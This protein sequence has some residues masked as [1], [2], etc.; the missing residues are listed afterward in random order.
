MIPDIIFRNGTVCDGTG[1]PIREC[2]IA[3][4]NG[5]IFDMGEI[6]TEGKKE[7]DCSGLVVSPG[8]I[9]IHSHSDYTLVADP[10]ALSAIYQGVTLEVIGNCG[11]GCF[12]IRDPN[13]SKRIV[14]GYDGKI[15]LTW[16]GPAAYLHDL[17]AGR[18]AVNVI[19]LVPNGQL[20]LATV[21]FTEAPA[22]TS[23]IKDMKKLLEEGLE[24]GCWGYSTGL[25]YASEAGA[26]EK[27]ITELCK[28][29]AKHDVIYTTHTRN[30]DAGAVKSVVEAIRTARNAE[31]Q[32]Q[33]SHLMLRG[34]REPTLQ[35]IDLVEE[36]RA[37]GDPIWFDMHTRLYG[38]T[39][40]SAM[41]P[42]WVME[43]TPKEQKV[44]LKDQ[45]V[46][47]KIRAF[48]SIVTG[49]GDWSKVILTDNTVA[50]EF[51]RMTFVEI[52]QK[53]GK[54]P[55]D[56]AC[57]ILIESMSEGASPPMVLLRSYTEDLQAEVFSHGEC[58]P[59]SDAATLGP[60]GPFAG[61]AF[62]GAYT[63]AAWFYRFMVNE[64][65]LMSP[66]EAVYRL[67]GKPA[68]IL[69][70]ADRGKLQIGMRADVV[71]FDSLAFTDRGTTFEPSKL[72]TGM[73][74]VLVNG[75]LSLLDGAPTGDRG[76]QVIR[77]SH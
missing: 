24:A 21:G 66:A 37:L 41:L 67:T 34:G 19:A 68:E 62:M 20:R 28:V 38:F 27:E 18:P 40:L 8:F 58:V 42:S 36:A 10:R 6:N 3:V 16:A 31:V 59:A 23:D 76:G 7:I 43:K 73:Q 46:R 60:D 53:L 32:L 74:H 65:K 77:H 30:R 17:E 11:H 2:D 5:K 72:A 44:M 15:P 22:S 52:G 33:I 55:H 48:K 4:L 14:Y 63:W 9:D 26:G 29:A 1:G 51:N 13:I 49:M 57:D 39:F 12:P 64:R 71:A 45:D 50:P 35:C 56:S 69:G 47:D 25:E 70:L 75:V 61:S 54:D